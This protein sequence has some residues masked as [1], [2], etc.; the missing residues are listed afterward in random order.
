[1]IENLP[2]PIQYA[3]DKAKTEEE[4]LEI[5]RIWEESKKQTEQLMEGINPLDQDKRFTLTLAN[6]NPGFSKPKEGAK[7][8][9]SFELTQ[10]EWANFVDANTTGMVIECDCYVTNRN[11]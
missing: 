1:M 9:V 5:L 7:Y 4:K 11:D 10:Q 3:Y 6:P 8:R 2:L